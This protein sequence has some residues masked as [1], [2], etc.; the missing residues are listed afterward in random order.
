MQIDYA[1]MGCQAV[2]ECTGVHLTTASCQPYFDAGIKKLIVS[3]PFKDAGD[4]IIN[5]VKGCNEVRGCYI[6]WVPIGSVANGISE[7]T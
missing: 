6:F 7:L 1:G 4:N 3:A 5:I 2:M